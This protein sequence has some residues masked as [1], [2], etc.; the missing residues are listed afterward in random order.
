MSITMNKDS[1]TIL[2]TA[3]L[4]GAMAV[5]IGAFSAHGLKP[6]LIEYQRVETFATAVQY[7]F[8]H[9]IAL[10]G[11]GTI[12]LHMPLKRV[13]W[14]YWFFVLGIVIFSGSLYLL[15]LTNYTL[16]GAITPIGGILFILGWIRMAI[17][18]WHS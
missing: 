15:S 12:H 13:M 16:L 8:F 14:C 1:R 4:L 9:I 11:L 7:H 17:S 10:T 18:I 5:M 2:V 6:L 3:S